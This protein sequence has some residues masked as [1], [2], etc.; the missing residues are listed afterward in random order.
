MGGIGAIRSGLERRRD[1]EVHAASL[2]ELSESMGQEITPIVLDV[3]GRTVELQGSVDN[4]YGEW[5]RILK[6]IYQRDN[7]QIAE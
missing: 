5:R 2:R 3:E 1:A 6:D 7:A 4:Q